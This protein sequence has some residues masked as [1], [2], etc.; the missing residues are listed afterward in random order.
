MSDRRI[1]L[2]D[3]SPTIQKVVNLTFADEGIDVVCASDGD[4]A[5]QMVS[6]FTPDLVL[7]DVNMP[8]K[9]GYELCAALRERQETRETPVILLVGSFEPFDEEKAFQVGANDYFTKPFQ[10]IRQLVNTVSELMRK[11]ETTEASTPEEGSLSEDTQPDMDTGLNA[12]DLAGAPEQDDIDILYRQSLQ[13]TV[14]IPK[15]ATEEHDA[16]TAGDLTD[17]ALDDE[18]IETEVAGGVEHDENADHRAG[19]TEIV[20]PI[21]TGELRFTESGFD[22]SDSIRFEDTIRDEYLAT[23]DSSD[24]GAVE[25]PPETG[26]SAEHVEMQTVPTIEPEEEVTRGFEIVPPQETS[27]DEAADNGAGDMEE[28]PAAPRNYDDANVLDLPAEEP[29]PARRESPSH[30]D[31]QFSSEMMDQLADRIAEKVSET[32]ARKLAGLVLPEVIR[33]MEEDRNNIS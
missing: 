21:D 1:L 16:P 2:A 7:A 14:E 8:G 30:A 12:A 25:P 24:T 33:K 5:F 9:T 17:T 29:E 20:S 3:D 18:L 28:M 15:E 10:S 23:P 27:A 19:H 4:S 6:E 31:P 22:S 11:P 26:F 32:L 13:K